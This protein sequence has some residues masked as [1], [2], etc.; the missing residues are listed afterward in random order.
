MVT[1]AAKR[2]A[3]A[4]LKE[5]FR[6]SERRAGEAIGCCRAGLRKREGNHPVEEEEVPPRLMLGEAAV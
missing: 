6:T 4:H 5:A 1:L 2:N 3:V